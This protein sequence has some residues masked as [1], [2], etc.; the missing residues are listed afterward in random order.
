MTEQPGE[1]E[2]GALRLPRT[3]SGPPI[4]P[5]RTPHRQTARPASPC[6]RRARFLFPPSRV[7]FPPARPF[8]FFGG[9][10]RGVQGG[11]KLPPPIGGRAAAGV[12][13]FSEANK[14]TVTP[15]CFE[16]AFRCGEYKRAA[17]F[18]KELCG[19]FSF[20]QLNRVRLSAHSSTRRSTISTSSSVS[21]IRLM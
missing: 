15:E 2:P 1:G 3:P 9:Q 6:R 10:E 16:G 19:A 13:A 17:G 4:L 21:V 12:R 11:A 14:P 18:H 8:A 5:L 7:R 20:F